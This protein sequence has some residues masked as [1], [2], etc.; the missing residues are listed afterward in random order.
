MLYQDNMGKIMHPDEVDE[1]APWEIE[2][3]GIHV[4]EDAYT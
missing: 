3:R 2:E 4:Y 1:L